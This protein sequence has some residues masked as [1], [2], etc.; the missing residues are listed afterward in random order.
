MIRKNQIQ[1]VVALEW[2]QRK[3]AG[4]NCKP[5]LKVRLRKTLGPEIE[6]Y[7][8]YNRNEAW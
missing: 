7:R 3:S 8:P 1:K 6:E 4:R 5:S 2:L